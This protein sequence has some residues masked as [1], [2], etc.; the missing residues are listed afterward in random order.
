MLETIHRIH[1]SQ[2]VFIKQDYAALFHQEQ[3]IASTTLQLG[4]T[5]KKQ[6]QS[7]CMSV[8]DLSM[9]EFSTNPQTPTFYSM[10]FYT[11]SATAC[12]KNHSHP[13]HQ[14]VQFDTVET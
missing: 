10:L 7:K 9:A 8:S 6:L 3:K 4:Q 5:A 2:T 14:L 11:F 13:N 12:T 1:F